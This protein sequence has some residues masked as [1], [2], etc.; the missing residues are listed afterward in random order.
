MSPFDIRH[1]FNVHDFVPPPTPFRP[2][3]KHAKDDTVSEPFVSRSSTETNAVWVPSSY[4]G[5]PEIADELPPST[6]ALLVVA[7]GLS[8][9]LSRLSDEAVIRRYPCTHQLLTLLC[10]ELK[11]SG[12]TSASVV[13]FTNAMQEVSDLLDPWTQAALQRCVDARAGDAQ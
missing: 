9:A 2:K 8:L 11:A 7:G 1:Y 12:R 4:S 10:K 6:K 5:L 3:R 13:L